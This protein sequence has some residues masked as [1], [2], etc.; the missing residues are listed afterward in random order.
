MAISARIHKPLMTVDRSLARTSY[1]FS[2]GSDECVRACVRF[3]A[4]RFVSMMGEPKKGN[5]SIFVARHCRHRGHLCV[6]Y[7][8]F[9]IRKYCVCNER[10]WLLNNEIIDTVNTGPFDD[11]VEWH[12]KLKFLIEIQ[13]HANEYCVAFLHFAIRFGRII[14]TMPSPPSRWWVMVTESEKTHLTMVRWWRWW[15]SVNH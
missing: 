9:D 10:K 2:L 1:A 8:G 7:L 14:E 12:S 3:D 13:R 11:A 4:I 6:P 15:K 5:W